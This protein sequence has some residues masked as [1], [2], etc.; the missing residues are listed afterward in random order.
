[1]PVADI[2]TFT[3][4]AAGESQFWTYGWPQGADVGPTFAAA[5]FF[6]DLANQGT[7]STLLMTK[8]QTLVFD[9]N[10]GGDVN[11][12]SYAATVRNDGS[13]GVSY[14]LQIGWFA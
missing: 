7:I 3:T 10:A 2:G 4:I 13:G 11:A 8:T 6:N 9:P 12:I 14:R 5:R 1:M